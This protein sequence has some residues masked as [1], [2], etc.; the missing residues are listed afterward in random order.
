MINTYIINLKQSEDRRLFMEAQLNLFPEL[1]GNFIDATD[2]RLLTDETI[3]KIY[4]EEL[5]IKTLNRKMVKGEIGVALSQMQAMHEITNDG[6]FGL[7][8]EDDL[9]ISPYL[10]DAFTPAVNFIQNPNPRIVLFTP[11]PQY[12]AINPIEINKLQ[13]R[14]IYKVW[15]DACFAACY[16]INKAACQI[17]LNEYPK[18]SNVIDNWGYFIRQNSIDIR[19]VVPHVVTFSKYGLFASTINIEDN[20]DSQICQ[21]KKRLSVFQRI[22]FKIRNIY[23]KYKYKV[24]SNQR[25]VWFNHLDIIQP[26]F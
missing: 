10:S 22:K 11:V 25:D 12:S 5:A 3:N 24:V 19:A 16:L 7:I 17:I 1:K 23:Y 2:A 26:N 21:T 6:G 14:H 18:V 9:L 8:M 4:D 13:N 20:R 15:N